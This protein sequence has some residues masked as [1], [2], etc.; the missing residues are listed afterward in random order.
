M[1]ADREQLRSSVEVLENLS[2]VEY[3]INLTDFLIDAKR[4]RTNPL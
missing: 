3:G 4:S 2:Q 1:K